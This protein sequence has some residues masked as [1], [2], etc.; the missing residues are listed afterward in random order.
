MSLARPT[1]EAVAPAAPTDPPRPGRAAFAFIFVTVAL[2][3]LALGVMIPV[4]PKLVV[5]LEGGDMACAAAIRPHA[6]VPV[7]G[8]PYLLA[9]ALLA[10]GMAWGA[11]ATR[12]DA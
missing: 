5:Q 12:G 1:P 2:D 7:P 10:G 3:M 9:A 4:L 6:A 8:A 11:R